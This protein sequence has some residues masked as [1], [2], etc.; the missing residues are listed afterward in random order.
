MTVATKRKRRWF[1]F[2]LRTWL[3]LFVVIGA[4]LGWLAPT[5]HR[6]DNQRRAVE[7]LQDRAEGSVRYEYELNHTEPPGPAWL[8]ESVGEDYFASVACVGV[9]RASDTSL[10]HLRAFPNVQRLDIQ[11]EHLTDADLKYLRG[12]TNLRMLDL[13]YTAITDASREVLRTYRSL[14][15]LNLGDTM[16]T[17]AS[18]ECLRSLTSLKTL[19]LYRTGVTDAGLA[20]L[21]SLT[22]LEQL[23]LQCTH[24]TDAGLDHL[25]TLKRL[26]DLN[27]KGTQVTD[28]GIEKLSRALPKCRITNGVF[29]QSSLR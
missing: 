27:L 7:W 15:N 26:E 3:L 14:E 21:Q 1:Q 20:H 23:D 13:S 22:N 25:Q 29:F 28:H 24:V 19:N 4:L 10:E 9:L 18:L 5:I 11:D 8:R 2:S 6:A 16:V 12:P 17:D